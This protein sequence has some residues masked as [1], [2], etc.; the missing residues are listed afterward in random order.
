MIDALPPGDQ[1]RL[2]QRLAPRL[3]NATH[4]GQSAESDSSLAWQEFRQAGLRLA[5]TA[6]GESITQ[7]I[8]DMRR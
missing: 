2:L 4:A 6:N 7:A 3:A 1:A 5:G 8:T